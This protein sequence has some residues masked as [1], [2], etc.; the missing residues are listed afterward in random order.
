M[1]MVDLKRLLYNNYKLALLLLCLLILLT[2]LGSYELRRVEEANA[3]GGWRGQDSYRIPVSWCA[4]HGSQ[5]ADNP[6]IPNPW[7][8]V[9]RTTDDVLWRRHERATDNIF[10]NDVGITFRSAINDALHTSLD[11]PKI[12]DPVI[13]S[14][15]WEGNLWLYDDQSDPA[16]NEINR[17]LHTCLQSWVNMAKGTGAVNGIPTINIKQFLNIPRTNIDTSVIG[18]SMCTDLAPPDG[19]CEA[20]YDGYVFVIDNFYTAPLA[21]GGQNNDPFDQNLGHEFGHSL[22][23]AHRT[24]TSDPTAL[25]NWRQVTTTTPAGETYVS[26]IKLNPQEVLTVRDNV[27]PP[28]IRGVET[29]PAGEVQ[30]AEV[31]ESIAIDDVGEN[32][33]LLPYQDIS[34]V[35]AILDSRNNITYFMQNLFGY[36]PETIISYNQTDLQY[37]TLV[38]VDNNTNTGGNETILES[39][40]VPSTAFRGADLAFLAEPVKNNN[41]TNNTGAVWRLSQGSPNVQAISPDLARVELRTALLEVHYASNTTNTPSNIDRLPVYESITTIINNT[42]DSVELDKPFSLQAIVS[43]NGTIL[44][45]LYRETEPAQSTLVLTNP[46]F[47]QCFVNEVAQTGKN[48]T[49]QV[50]GLL[51]NENL[52]ALLGPRAVANG[53]T[54]AAG[55]STIQFSVPNDTSPGLHLMTVGI[56]DTAL[57][58]DCEIEI[59]NEQNSTQQT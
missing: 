1:K 34:Y 9:D 8:G 57:T 44:D 10:I 51:P 54:S 19:I 16:M 15:S 20:P 21:T 18:A 4:V 47:P 42:G 23:L 30:E 35:R 7:G 5:A 56:D 43:S 32:Q 3:I 25:M 37:W 17:M 12:A 52:H 26:N 55:N 11:F 41:L 28:R 13:E 6:N 2:E 36:I 29:D 22:G 58:A 40:G 14:P 33:S 46:L 59:Q 39:I 50:S 49:I 27:L 24:D 45:T 31:V 48:A 38:N 53:T